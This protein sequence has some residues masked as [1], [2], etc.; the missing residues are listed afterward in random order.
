MPKIVL[1]LLAA[2]LLI[3]AAPSPDKPYTIYLPMS[4]Q[5]YTPRTLTLLTPIE[6][7]VPLVLHD[8][9]ADPNTIYGVYAP[10]L[11]AFWVV[12]QP[13][14]DGEYISSGPLEVTQFASAAS[15]GTIGL[16]AHGGTFLAGKEFY[17]LLPDD[18]IALIYGDGTIVDYRV[19][20][21]DW[22][23][24]LDPDTRTTFYLP[25]EDTTI[26]WTRLYFRYYAVDGQLTLQ[27]CF[28]VDGRA[29]GGLL[30]VTAQPEE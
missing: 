14:G 23:T 17:R 6:T 11:F 13:P 29:T 20:A 4:A 27:T 21:T 8:S 16:L 22:W 7:F 1:L 24:V 3:G 18:L 9:A 19:T 10:N 2:A 5:T 15:F 26:D 12:Q 25:A 30:F 28:E